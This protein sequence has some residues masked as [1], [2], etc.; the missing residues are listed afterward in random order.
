[1]TYA[2][3]YWLCVLM[4]LITLH[5]P[6][7]QAAPQKMVYDGRLLDAAGNAL[8]VPHD[9]RFS[10]WIGGDATEEIFNPDG[11]IK[12]AST[13]FTD[14][15]EVHTITPD[16]N[17]Y[18]EVYLGSIEG[19]LD[20]ATLS[21]DQMNDLNLQVEV[22]R[23][24]EPETAYEVL[25]ADS[26]SDSQDRSAFTSVP[27]A[28]NANLLDG[29]SIG[30]FEGDIPVIGAGNTLDI[31]I[32]PG[33]TLSPVFTINAG[34]SEQA[35]PVS[36][37]QFGSQ[38]GAQLSYDTVGSVFEFSDDVHIHGD[39]TVDGL[40]NNVDVSRMEEGH[41][42]VT[43]AQGLS[44]DVSA[45]GYRLDGN[46]AYFP[47]AAGVA[48]EA[49]ATSFVYMNPEGLTVNA[50]GFPVNDRFI[51]LARILTDT[52]S[53]VSVEDKRVLLVDDR[54][55]LSEI[56]FHPEYANAVYTADGSDNTGQLAV[57]HA[58]DERKNYYQW[59]STKDT[60]QDYDIAVVYTLPTGFQRWDTNALTLSYRTSTA[61][62]GDNQ[63]DLSVQDTN[64]AV[65]TLSGEAV[66]LVSQE[67]ITT[68][69]G[70]TGPSV[71]TAGEE[72]LLR[73]K[74]HSKN[75]HHA[76]IGSLKLQYFERFPKQ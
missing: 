42:K 5:L 20:F 65:A 27:F 72:I 36:T 75:L 18:F 55:R 48:L 19:M 28:L 21:G 47:G 15:Q 12:E 39:L 63:I 62:S 58:E 9:I 52:G 70:I 24:D 14:W 2:K 13:G 59:R 43:E 71:W 69:V 50:T 38:L 40:I 34:G 8:T 29:R 46:T 66:G 76:E 64:G 32:I 22:K 23:S 6:V 11:T 37:L 73:I 26:S 49:N 10:L 44:V 54:E 45:G 3:P 60:L 74:L 16:A 30:I 25:D 1:M 61:V 51:P 57:K 31:G 56:V 67:W 53:V 41:L 17:G 35:P 33:G 4:L 68:T 7:A